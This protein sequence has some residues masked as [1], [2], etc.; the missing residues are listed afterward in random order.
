[1][2]SIPFDP[3]S[4]KAQVTACG[5]TDNGTGFVP[6]WGA[7]GIAVFMSA[8]LGAMPAKHAFVLFDAALSLTAVKRFG[9]V[10]KKAGVPSGFNQMDASLYARV[11]MIGKN[12]A[13]EDQLRQEPLRTVLVIDDAAAADALTVLAGLL[14]ESI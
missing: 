3:V 6:G 1:M 13:L 14:P 10:I 2:P 12:Q 4:I 8:G 7:N 11:I 9:N 5:V